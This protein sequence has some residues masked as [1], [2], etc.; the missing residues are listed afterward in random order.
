M[1][2]V[3]EMTFG[4]V[5]GARWGNGYRNKSHNNNWIFA[6]I[7]VSVFPYSCPQRR[8]TFKVIGD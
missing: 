4:G 1:W 5:K 3:G 7:E 8:K 6:C 2:M